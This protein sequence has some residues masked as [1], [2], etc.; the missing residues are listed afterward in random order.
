MVVSMGGGV[1]KFFCSS[2]GLV[3]VGLPLSIN[4]QGCEI[5]V[6]KHPGALVRQVVHGKEIPWNL[7]TPKAPYQGKACR[8]A[9]RAFARMCALVPGRFWR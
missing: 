7:F 5:H 6:E 3:P 1:L 8:F 9:L 2:K 4:L